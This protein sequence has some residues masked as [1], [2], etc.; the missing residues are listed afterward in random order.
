MQHGGVD[1]VLYLLREAFAGEPDQDGDGH[2]LLCN[3]RAVDESNWNIAAPGGSRTIKEILLHVGA[4]KYVYDDHAFGTGHLR[5]D[6]KLVN[7][8]PDSEPH[9]AEVVEWLRAG[10]R[11]L[12]HHVDALTDS[13]LSL[14][15]KANWGAMEPTRWLIGVVI[16]H[17]LYHAGEINHLRALLAGNDAWPSYET[18]PAADPVL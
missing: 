3:L 12:Y 11:R 13:D 4:C 15:R 10:Q 7:P 16:Q 17:D 9:M 5:W 18:R 6:S 8:W 1:E 2:S 14:P